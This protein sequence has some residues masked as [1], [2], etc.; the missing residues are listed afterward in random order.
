MTSMLVDY[1]VSETMARSDGAIDFPSQFIEGYAYMQNKFYGTQKGRFYDAK[2]A[3]LW[4]PKQLLHIDNVEVNYIAARGE[5][6][7]YLA[8]INESEKDVTANITLNDK[9]VP[10]GSY[11][12][13]I[14]ENNQAFEGKGK[15]QGSMQV[16]IPA[17]GLTAVI[18]DDC[19]IVP[20]FQGK[21]MGETKDS[22]WKHGLVD[23]KEPNGRAMILNL[24]KATSKAF[25]Y[26]IDDATSFKE[27]RLSYDLGKGPEILTD[28]T[29][30]WE[31]TLP[32]EASVNKL[33]FSISGLPENGQIRSGKAQQLSKD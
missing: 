11:P 6:A 13:R 17:K 24:G 10:K 32:L 20:R 31:F 4:M 15:T 25:I 18:L 2:D 21:V 27:V 1:L 5:N 19:K 12:V 26:L 30:P 9:L 3:I 33:S 7:L 23:F 8:L 22:A 28:K 29:F 16:T 14:S